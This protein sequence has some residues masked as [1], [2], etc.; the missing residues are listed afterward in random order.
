MEKV[1][2]DFHAISSSTAKLYAYRISL[3]DSP[4]SP[5]KRLYR[6]PVPRDVD[7][8]LLEEV[9]SMFKGTHDF[10]SFAGQMEQ[11]EKASGGKVSTVRTVH[12]V[13]VVRE[14]DGDIMFLFLLEGALYKMVRN[15]CGT[16]L[17]CARGEIELE[18]VKDLLE[19]GWAG[20]KDNKSKPAKPEGLTLEKVWFDNCWQ[21][22]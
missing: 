22:F 2:L 18:T 4:Q 13:R 21:D 8:V 1:D 5:F 20:R 11:K 16:A 9:L 7:L 19:G 14:G 3:G 6:V 15:M 17:A 10:R 12:D